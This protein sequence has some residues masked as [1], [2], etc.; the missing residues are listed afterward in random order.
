MHRKIGWYITEL[1]SRLAGRMPKEE[2]ARFLDETEDH[3][4]CSAEDL[5]PE[6]GRD[7]ADEAVTRFGRPGTLARR[8]L[9]ARFVPPHYWRA[10]TPVMALILVMVCSLSAWNSFDDVRVLGAPLPQV[11]AIGSIPFLITALALA[12]QRV[13]LAL[14]IASVVG[15]F[16]AA[17]ILAGTLL[18]VEM[19][20]GSGST[21][22]T[23]QM[24]LRGLDRRLDMMEASAKSANAMMESIFTDA[25]TRYDDPLVSWTSARRTPVFQVPVALFIDGLGV[26]VPEMKT[27]R[28]G[29]EAQVAWFHLGR[30]ALA[31]WQASRGVGEAL[32]RGIRAEAARPWSARFVAVLPGSLGAGAQ[33]LLVLMGVN[34]LA[35]LLARGLRFRRRREFA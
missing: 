22:V 31:K 14:M 6:M 18:S 25:R 16:G 33:M 20:Y 30:A 24:P 2:L 10:A 27:F 35:L 19:D 11:L 26:S 28:T 8:A 15:S 23:V 12:R 3:L 21:P 9:Q 7:A 5:E 4:C 34:E 1:D 13:T 32:V 29:P 17:A